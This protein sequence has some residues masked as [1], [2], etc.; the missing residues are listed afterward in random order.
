MPWTVLPQSRSAPGGGASTMSRPRLRPP[1]EACTH[2]DKVNAN[3]MAHPR[4][5]KAP[6]E[7]PFDPRRMAYGDFETIVAA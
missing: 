1:H 4:I 3:M 5:Q 2:R 6:P 7:M